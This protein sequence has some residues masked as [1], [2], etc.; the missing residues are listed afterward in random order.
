[1]PYGAK[2][3][4]S[5]GFRAL[6]L[7]VA[8]IQFLVCLDAS[9]STSPAEKTEFGIGIVQTSIAIAAIAMADD[10]TRNSA[11]Y[12]NHCLRMILNSINKSLFY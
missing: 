2:R 10:V 3:V 9:G 5:R 12:G 7:I 11:S 4:P 1:V 8:G 6:E